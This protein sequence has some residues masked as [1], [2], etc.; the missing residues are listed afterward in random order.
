MRFIQKV[1][2]LNDLGVTF[3][4]FRETFMKKSM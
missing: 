1:N 3:D 4:S 2:H